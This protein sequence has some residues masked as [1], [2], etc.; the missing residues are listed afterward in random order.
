MLSIWIYICTIF[1]LYDFIAIRQGVA[2]S[3]ILLSYS[4]LVE[5]N[6]K[7]YIFMIFLASLFHFSAI[8]LILIYPFVIRQ[9]KT[10]VL[11]A[12]LCLV[13]ILNY[14]QIQIGIATLFLE[15]IGLPAFTLEKLNAYSIAED[16]S[17]LSIKQLFI[18]IFFISMYQ[19]LKNTKPHIIPMINIYL[20]G[21]IIST[22]LSDIGQISYRL[23]WY[24]FVYEIV[25]IPIFLYYVY[26]KLKSSF[27]YICLIFLFFLIY[28]FSLYN[29]VTSLYERGFSL[30]FVEGLLNVF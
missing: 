4:S 5:K 3:F 10:S 25:L 11:Y 1:I 9:Y 14:F 15:N 24:F 2:L 30:Y 28:G 8:I 20:L 17:F 19:Y 18:G 23:R 7:K 12:I 26:H 29:F 27:I 22:L 6:F 16:T 21:M 13:F